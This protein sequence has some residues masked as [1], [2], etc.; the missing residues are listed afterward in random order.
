[1]GG[2]QICRT[3]LQ[4]RTCTV[5]TIHGRSGHAVWHVCSLGHDKTSWK[6]RRETVPEKIEKMGARILSRFLSLRPAF[7]MDRLRGLGIGLGLQGHI[8]ALGREHAQMFQCPRWTHVDHRH[9]N[10]GPEGPFLV[11]GRA[12]AFFRCV[13]SCE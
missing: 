10:P 12:E 8:R 9:E 1:M 11:Q 4:T 5:H 3:D 7:H 2:R 13:L 6:K